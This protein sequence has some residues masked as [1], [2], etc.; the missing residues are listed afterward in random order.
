M[1]EKEAGG[2]GRGEIMGTFIVL[3]LTL[4]IALGIT[5]ASEVVKNKPEWL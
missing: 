2:K 5:F 3:I 1:Q 4:I